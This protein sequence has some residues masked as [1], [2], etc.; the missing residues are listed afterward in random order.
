MFPDERVIEVVSRLTGVPVEQVKAQDTADLRLQDSMDSLDTVE[1]LAEVT[2]EFDEETVRW[3]IRY[4]QALTER[5]EARR[6]KRSMLSQP[7]C[8]DPLW[9]RELDR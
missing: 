3:A 6:S 8:P 9:G 4:I 5:A 1:L 7:D 2:E